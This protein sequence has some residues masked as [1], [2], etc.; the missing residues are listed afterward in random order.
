MPI[1]KENEL[2][3]HKL[4]LFKWYFVEGQL[5]QRES[6]KFTTTELSTIIF[7]ERNKRDGE[8]DETMQT[9]E[10]DHLTIP[11]KNLHR[12]TLLHVL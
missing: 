12:T 9:G 8:K 2:L 7:K 4:V 3:Q 1:C 6:L 10:M 11:K 5:L